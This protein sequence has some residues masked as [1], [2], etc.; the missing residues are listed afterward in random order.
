MDEEE[1]LLKLRDLEQDL[2]RKVD[3]KSFVIEEKKDVG[4]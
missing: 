4:N 3:E 1:K 2:K